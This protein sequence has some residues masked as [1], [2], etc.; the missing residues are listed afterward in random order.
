MEPLQLAILAGSIKDPDQKVMYDDR[1][2]DIPFEDQTDLVCITVDTF[3]ARR[4]YQ[5]A[6]EFKTRKFIVLLGGM[7]ISL[8]PDEALQH[9]DAVVIGDLEPVW[10]KLLADVRSAALH[11]VSQGP[12]GIPQENCFPDR[13]IFIG[14]KILTD[15]P[16]TVQQRLCFQLFI[17][18]SFTF[19]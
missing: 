12:F 6:D 15:I 11:K 14:K 16:G 10:D 8:L 5:I 7:H 4:A 13:S 9:A 1:L 19:F 2:E 3:S 18:F 17:L